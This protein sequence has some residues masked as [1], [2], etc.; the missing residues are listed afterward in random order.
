[1]KDDCILDHKLLV[2]LLSNGGNGL[3]A[4]TVAVIDHSIGEQHSVMAMA[5]ATP[6]A[7]HHEVATKVDGEA[8]GVKLKPPQMVAAV[9][10]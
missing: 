6:L 4:M 10:L 9:A 5:R 7:L 2:E 1:M 3:L 8:V